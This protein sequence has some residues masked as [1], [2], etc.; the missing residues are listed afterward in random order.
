MLVEKQS[1]DECP[2]CGERLE[3]AS[4]TRPHY[5]SGNIFDQARHADEWSIISA[6]CPQCQYVR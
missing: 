5:G 1:E 2:K 6:R 4:N 3:T